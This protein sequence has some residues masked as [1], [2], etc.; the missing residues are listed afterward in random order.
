MLSILNDILAQ[1]TKTPTADG[2]ALTVMLTQP[3]TAA[4]AKNFPY[5]Y[6][7]LTNIVAAYIG[8][9]HTQQV[10]SQQN[11]FVGCGV[12]TAGAAGVPDDLESDLIAA[13]VD[14]F[15]RYTLPSQFYWQANFTRADA[16]TYGVGITRIAMPSEQGGIARALGPDWPE[17]EITIAGTI[18]FNQ[19]TFPQPQ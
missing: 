1:T 11:F 12:K 15:N 13:V 16:T 7:R 5:I 4:D 14:T 2:D 19:S 3:R 18:Y 10:D 6:P 9:S 8:P 17:N